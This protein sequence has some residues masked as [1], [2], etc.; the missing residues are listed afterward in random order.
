MLR[1]MGSQRVG[2]YSATKLNR[3]ELPT[4]ESWDIGKSNKMA[5]QGTMMNCE[6]DLKPVGTLSR[7]QTHP[8][9]EA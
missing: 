7:N 1:F 8:D 9:K 2:H 4:V 5:S 3:T 6:D